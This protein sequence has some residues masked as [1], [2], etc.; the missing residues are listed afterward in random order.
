M[1]RRKR[2]TASA[3]C[4]ARCPSL[5]LA[6]TA[7]PALSSSG[8]CRSCRPPTH[9]PTRQQ[10]GCGRSAAPTDATR[11]GSCAVWDGELDRSIQQLSNSPFCNAVFVEFLCVG[12]IEIA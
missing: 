5:P 11:G 7:A 3:L 12:S 4:M 1:A 8:T 6:V 10:G 2:P 9:P